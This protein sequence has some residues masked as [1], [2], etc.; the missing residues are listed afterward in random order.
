MRRAADPTAVL[1]VLDGVQREAVEFDGRALTVLGAPGTGKTTTA[2]EMVVEAVARG[3]RPEHCLL[4]SPTRVAAGALRDRVTSR[5]A[6]TTTEPVSRTHQALGFGLLRQAASLR[7]LPAPRLLNGP[8]QDVVLKELL[9][10]YATGLAPEPP[11]PAYV[12]EAL[13]TRGFRAELRD[14]LM[15]A[16]E[17][18]QES[19]DL[20]RLGV[21]H[22]RPEWVAAAQVLDDYDEVTALSRP[23]AYDPA[24]ILGSAADLLLEDDEALRRVRDSVRFVVVDDAQELTSAAARLLRVVVGP[25]TQVRLVADPDTTVQG[26]RGADPRLFGTLATEW[27][28]D[29]VRRLQVSYRQPEALRAVSERVSARI[30]AV[31]GALHRETQT[32]SGGVVEVALLRAV[33]QEAAHVAGL[34]RRAHL[35][36]NVAWSDMAVIVRGQGRTGS[37]RRALAASGVPVAVPPTTVPL[38]DEP[39]VRPFLTLIEV[40]LRLA[41]EPPTDPDQA[42]ESALPITPEVATDVLTSPL[43]A[44][45]A[46]A[47][48]RMRRALRSVELE[49]GGSRTGDELLA[50]SVLDP[51]QL[52]L[53]GPEV[54]PARRVARVVQAGVTAARVD[55]ATAETVLWAMW[56]ASGLAEPWS[57]AALAG[58]PAGAR[59]DRDLDAVVALF[60]AAAAYVDRLP[61]SGPADFLEHVRGQDVPGDTLVARA[62]DDECVSLMT[63]AGA[64]GRE[65]HTVVVAGVQEGVWPDLRLRGSLLGSERLVDVLTERGSTLRAAQAAVRYD[66][67]RQFLVACS[68]ARERLVVTAVRS[69]D[70]QPSVYLDIVDPLDV[71]GDSSHDELREFTDVQRPMTLQAAVAELRREVAVG[72]DEQRAEAAAALSRLARE[73]VPGA[74]PASW[75]AL[76]ELSD[77][78]PLR[79]PDQLV[80]VSPSKVDQFAT[81]G[82]NWLLTTCGGEGPDVGAATLGTLVHEVAAELGDTEPER[83]HDVLDERWPRLG[84]GEGWISERKRQ[85][86]HRMLDRL[87]DYLDSAAAMGW[88]KAAVEIAF[89]VEVGRARLRGR[90]DRLE[91]HDEHGLRIIDLKTGS[92]KPTKDQL[93]EHPQLG[94]YQVAVAEG[95]FDEGDVAGGAALVQLG[96]AGLKG[97]ADVQAQPAIEPGDEHSWAH[98]VVRATADGMGAATFVATVSDRCGVCPVRRSCPLQ[99]EG[100]AI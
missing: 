81:C 86:A 40:A 68:R 47:L 16:V 97:R 23:G 33:S 35:I 88:R 55:N 8:E 70:E 50:A 85:E 10:G 31:S 100:Q 54:A 21:E 15:R 39:A 63:P 2:V 1:P 93:T 56:Q 46:V 76:T 98:D 82:L 14:L 37:L 4:L 83:M 74:D 91:Q 24:W 45:D 11:W 51:A 71:Q 66:E 90:V 75:W 13:P 43:G 26:F 73:H 3:V 69:E 34:L 60:G 94:A 96:K 9:E 7:G 92:S 48:R 19:D 22:D 28:A 44:A 80:G 17:H 42:G 62:P 84:L 57:S 58:G 87:A 78:R 61:Q 59:A 27:G 64:A 99:P 67:T 20:R 32:R 30:G 65:W 29:E 12:R 18:G 49:S 89:D 52:T 41:A 6:G 79:R 72:D 5:L 53:H 25:Q 95:G 38:R 36:D 77:D